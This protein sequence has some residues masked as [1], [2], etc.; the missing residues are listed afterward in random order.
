MHLHYYFIV[1]VLECM[2]LWST[3]EGDV[4]HQCMRTTP[5]ADAIDIKN[6]FESDLYVLEVGC[7][8]TLLAF[9]VLYFVLTSLIIP[10][11]VFYLTW[12]SCCDISGGFVSMF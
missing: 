2:P 1:V 5:V 11:L 6:P 12:V 10:L 7:C 3:R 9:C 4:R 8:L